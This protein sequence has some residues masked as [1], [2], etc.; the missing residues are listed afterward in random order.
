MSVD[1][2]TNVHVS[3]ADVP[4]TTTWA[5][6]DGNYDNSPRPSPTSA[7]FSDAHEHPQA[8]Q[9]HNRSISSSSTT[10][11]IFVENAVSAS[12]TPQYDTNPTPSDLPLAVS[13]PSDYTNPGPNKLQTH[14]S[15]QESESSQETTQSGDMAS[16]HAEGGRSTSDPLKDT[17]LSD[18]LAT[19][20]GSPETISTTSPNRSKRPLPRRATRRPAATL[21]PITQVPL[22]ADV[23]PITHSPDSSRPNSPIDETGKLWTSSTDITSSQTLVEMIMSTTSSG[24]LQ[25]LR[26]E[27]LARSQEIGEIANRFDPEKYLPRRHLSMYASLPDQGVHT[28][29]P[30]AS[31]SASGSSSTNTPP[32]HPDVVQSEDSTST[33]ES[34]S[35]CASLPS[36]GV[37]PSQP[38]VS[39]SKSEAQNSNCPAPRPISYSRKTRGITPSLASIVK[40]TESDC[41]PSNDNDDRGRHPHQR[42]RLFDIDRTG[43]LDS[44]WGSVPRSGDRNSPPPHHISH[45]IPLPPVS[46]PLVGSS[47]SDATGNNAIPD[48]CSP[49]QL[50][51]CHENVSVDTVRQE[52]DDLG[53][54]SDEEVSRVSSRAS[55][56]EGTY[57]YDE[58]YSNPNLNLPEDTLSTTGYSD[59]PVVYTQD[60]GRSDSGD[61]IAAQ[62]EAYYQQPPGH[63]SSAGYPS[64]DGDFGDAEASHCHSVPLSSYSSLSGVFGDTD[65]MEGLSEHLVAL[66]QVLSETSLGENGTPPPPSPSDR[67]S[68]EPAGISEVEVGQRSDDLASET[69]VN[70]EVES[71]QL[72]PLQAPTAGLLL[73]TS[74]TPSEETILNLGGPAAAPPLV[75]DNDTGRSPSAPAVSFQPQHASVSATDINTSEAPISAPTLLVGESQSEESAGLVD[76]ESEQDAEGE[77]EDESIPYDGDDSDED[78]MEEVP[79]PLYPASEA[80]ANDFLRNEVAPDLV[81]SP[82]ASAYMDFA[83]SNNVTTNSEAALMMDEAAMAEDMLTDDDAGFEV[84]IY[85]PNDSVVMAEDM[86]HNTATICP[87]ADL[88]DTQVPSRVERAPTLNLEMD[89]VPEGS[90]A[91]RAT[92]ADWSMD[93]T[94]SL[95]R[96]D[97][98]SQF[99]VPHAWLVPSA[100]RVSHGLT[101]D[102]LDDTTQPVAEANDDEEPTQTG[103]L[104]IWAQGTFMDAPTLDV[105][106]EFSRL[107]IIEETPA[108]ASIELPVPTFIS[109]FHSAY[110]SVNAN[111][112]TAPFENSSPPDNNES[113]AVEHGV[114]QRSNS[115]SDG[116][117]RHEQILPTRS[118]EEVCAAPEPLVLP[119]EKMA[120][121]PDAESNMPV[122]DSVRAAAAE[123]L[124]PEGNNRQASI[125]EE[126]AIVP[127]DSQTNGVLMDHQVPTGF[128][129]VWNI[130]LDIPTSPITVDNDVGSPEGILSPAESLIPVP[131]TIPSTTW[132]QQALE[133][134][135][136]RSGDGHQNIPAVSI[137][138]RRPHSNIEIPAVICELY[139]EGNFVQPRRTRGIP[140]PY[141]SGGGIHRSFAERRRRAAF[142]VSQAART[143]GRAGIDKT[144]TGKKKKPSDND[145]NLNLGVPDGVVGSMTA[146]V[147]LGEAFEPPHAVDD[148]ASYKTDVVVEENSPTTNKRVVVPVVVPAAAGHITPPAP[149]SPVAGRVASSAAPVIPPAV[150]RRVPA[151]VQPPPV[152][153]VIVIPPI[154]FAY[155]EPLASPGSWPVPVPVYAP[156]GQPPRRPMWD[157]FADWFDN[158]CDAVLEAVIGR[159]CGLSMLFLALGVV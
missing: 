108:V 23:P 33:S 97:R 131:D 106:L 101:D 22:P 132:V 129:V 119:V 125:E 48:P 117:V 6:N 66:A 3:E 28:N 14:S 84:T 158:A 43:W 21:R 107:S 15:V 36:Q 140:H 76:Y 149:A 27:Y 102:D 89:I 118:S 34:S 47:E 91:E 8:T 17:S 18:R 4:R 61:I 50:G 153:P 126:I 100:M 59:I 138:S 1:Q 92:R 88:A 2:N 124:G 57:H 134:L 46:G 141:R 12:T 68:H 80:D 145:S 128:E 24:L 10:S 81:D 32:P 159:N 67:I 104:T 77:M 70:E 58:G 64:L 9:L 136:A 13:L 87:E 148:V 154:E 72:S 26:Q 37:P 82:A 62:G 133:G 16:I 7:T 123:D 95:G 99:L 121:K 139:G 44:K 146:D 20:E 94:P 11:A 49:Q 30:E 157:V 127:G 115:E 143:A 96:A 113:D 155:E 45:V 137:S 63:S 156:P 79:I 31:A 83:S 150:A 120:T 105:T 29:Q 54:G 114:L 19:Q 75:E 151:P 56:D 40:L 41:P 130:E 103:D 147:R 98:P 74:A 35:P 144:I 90:Y 111:L 116:E 5:P 42:H 39:T 51:V 152:A 112:D 93:L 69:Q 71:G 55:S 86:D 65:A 60:E 38:E 142:D 85:N 110:D 53:E 109:T 52:E 122:P 78:D 25:D 73:D 135:E